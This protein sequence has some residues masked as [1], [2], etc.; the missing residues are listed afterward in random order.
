MEASQSR[1]D[2]VL[3]LGLGD[4]GRR[5]VDVLS[6]RSGGRLV[7]AAR[8]AGHARNVAGQAALVAALCD[9]P[10]AVEPAVADLDDRDGTAELLA[11]LQPDVI[12]L[13]ASRLTWWRVPEPASALPYG[14]WLPLHIPL[15]RALMEARNA[16]GVG[17]PVVA[18]AY[19]DA[20]G[21]V[22]AGAG[23]APE[24]GAGNVLEM[25]AK[26]VTVVAERAG[27]EREAVDVRLIAHHATERTAFSAFGG[28][29]GGEGGPIGP[30]PLHAGVTVNGEP[31]P[32]VEVR[33]LLT[34]P[35]ALL[36]G[37]ATHELTAAA[38]AAT[39]WAL[40]ADEPRRLHVPAPAGRP[41]GYPVRISRAGIDLD[42][43]PG[44]S[45]ADA[46]AV[47]AVAAR[48]DG[49]ERIEP[50]GSF[51]YCSWVTAALE[52]TLGLRVE[53]VEPGE[54][55]AIAAELEARLARA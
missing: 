31:L 24:T 42:L 15:V 4:L 16:A 44:M 2:T 27:V 21:P 30:P 41:G 18:L 25:A 6:H 54:S 49:I 47:N 55:D 23:L 11:R 33:E 45:E 28:L 40:L 48:W 14:V 29:A 51:V 12:V 35:Y 20:V 8:D 3:V 26:L 10:R 17:A 34:A 22:L 50:D 43:P 1:D 46:I 39:V 32:D 52:R 36:N 38:T 37:R 13:A 53:R 9:G 7:V 5:I 19:P